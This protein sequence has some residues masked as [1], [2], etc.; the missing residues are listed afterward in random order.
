MTTVTTNSIP[1][2]LTRKREALS[3]QAAEKARQVT[4]SL[5]FRVL[6]V[7]ALVLALWAT[8]IATFGY[9]ALILPMLAFVPVMFVVLLLITVGK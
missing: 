3:Q 2:S 8:A 6:G 7:L 1:S 5:E 9:A 4:G